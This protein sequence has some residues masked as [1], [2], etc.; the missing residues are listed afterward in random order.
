MEK[1]Y[2]PL[3]LIG[4]NLFM[5]YAWYGHLKDQK[6]SALWIVILTSWLV[7]LP[8]YALQVPGN[9]LGAKVYTLGQLK[10]MQEVITMTIFAGFAIFY[11]KVPLKLDYFWAALCLVAAAFFVFRG[12]TSPV[13]G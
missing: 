10:V 6:T 7:A 2:T 5:T 11:M 1:L 13:N 8:E 4:S 9:R 3:L 12:G